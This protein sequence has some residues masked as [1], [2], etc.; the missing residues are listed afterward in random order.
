MSGLRLLIWTLGWAGLTVV[1]GARAADTG[2]TLYETR[3]A[4]CHDQTGETRAPA[5]T[6]LRQMNH[7]RL[8]YALTRGSMR[9]HADGL[10]RDALGALM[11]FLAGRPEG[12]HELP[13]SA[14]CADSAI[15]IE[16]VAVRRWGLDDANTAFQGPTTTAI[17][18]GNVAGLRL[19][20]AFGVPET[21][22]MRSAPVIA[23][24]TLFLG[25]VSGQLFALDRA[26]GCVRWARRFDT[27]LRTALH[28]G[29]S[30]GRATLYFGNFGAEIF[31]VDALTG[32]T[33]WRRPVGLFE[34][35]TTTGSPVQHGARVFVPLSSYEVGVARR[36]EHPCCR[37]HG[38]VLALDAD[39]GD[40]L[41]TTRTT[42]DAR[43]TF[44]SSAGV[45]QWGPSG[46]TVWTTPAIDPERGVIYVGTG[47]NASSPATGTSDAIIALDMATGAVRWIFQATEGDAY[48]DAC[49]T[50]PLGANCPPER[51]PDHDFGA[52]VIMA[53]TSAGKPILLAGQK[54]GEV[55]ALDP[56]DRGRVMW[57]RR[58]SQGSWLGGVHW[59]MALE[60]ERLFVPIADP[61]WPLAGYTPRPALF[62]L[63]IDDGRVLWDHPLA[64]GCETTLEAYNAR[65]E[66][67][68]ECPWYYG[69]SAA[70]S[71][72]PGVVFAGAL[73][74]RLTAHSTHDGVPLWSFETARPFET[75]N[76]VPAHGGSIDS[77]AALPAGDMLYVQS[78]YS[79]FG[80]LPGN[81]LLAFELAPVSESGEGSGP[82][83]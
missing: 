24:N 25:T 13:A 66:P 14:Y 40:I 67:W 7:A 73:N 57:Q 34:W 9:V 8:R 64:R 5:L 28:L 51:G 78:G 29:T 65:T 83:K 21:S 52:S 15:E 6:A 63:S 45:Q 18:A 79:W 80:Q 60:G 61:E 3:C 50:W 32:D 35:S 47:Q 17:D 37:S 36:D 22:D 10:D 42:E 49:T 69:Y 23:G 19:K 38:A 46:A 41:W 39:S 75:I 44:V 71:S 81:V 56:D 55:H 30:R 4:A 72:V 27:P 48:N 53:R 77:A 26:S 54:S 31:A 43:P 59:G 68:P 2:A 76:G 70:V 74:G 16:P 58:L 1:A 33:V 82:V 12:V 11:A 20:W 62:A